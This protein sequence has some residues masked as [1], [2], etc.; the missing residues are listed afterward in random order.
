MRNLILIIIVIYPIV[1]NA[2]TFYI[3][4]KGND[5]NSGTN[6][7]F[8]WKTLDKIQNAANNAR[9]KAGDSVLFN[10]GEKFIG[11]IKWMNIWGMN[12]SGGTKKKPIIISAYGVGEKPLFMYLHNSAILPENRIVFH[13]A[14]VNN[15][16]ID[17]LQFKDLNN[18]GN[19]KNPGNCGIAIYLG[20]M[21]EATCNNFFINNVDIVG[22][23]M[24]I[25]IIGNY[26]RITNSLMTDFVNLKS[27]P[28]QIFEFKNDDYG[29][30]A[31]T[32]TGN[33]NIIKNNFISGAW[34]ESYDYG[35]NGG[36]FEFFNASSYN[37]IYNNTIVDCA[38]VAEFGG[39]NSNQ[40]SIN[41]FFFKNKI[42]N[43]GSMIW[44]NLSGIY[45][46][47]I[48]NINFHDNV[49][50]EDI[51]SRF[52]GIYTGLGVQTIEIKNM[53][54]PESIMF[55]HN[56]KNWRNNVY[57]ISH[58]FFTIKT[59]LKVFNKYDKCLIEKKNILLN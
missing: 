45:A 10:K 18:S 5:L 4:N 24:G 51:N 6:A 59:R 9:I 1:I 28:S 53:I 19:K 13:F 30:N 22:Y 15:I 40:S 46:I 37:I 3:S 54:T 34:A 43:C 11:S 2:T 41:N 27:T 12:C 47:K 21:N 56:G 48:G 49:V 44:A 31:V 17:G 55:A 14:G 32:I 50:I 20:A 29:A 7:Q 58:N 23:G 16:I 52:S 26:N 8:P 42:Q 39:H 35:W 38:G 33:Y 25:V 57:L 36:A